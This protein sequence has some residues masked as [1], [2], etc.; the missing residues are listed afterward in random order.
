MYR[1][2]GHARD[3]KYSS[4]EK[5]EAFFVSLFY[6][7]FLSHLIE[8]GM[9]RCYFRLWVQDSFCPSRGSFVRCIHVYNCFFLIDWYFCHKMSSLIKFFFV[10]MSVLS[11]ISIATPASLWFLFVRYFLFFSF[12]FNLS[13]LLSIYI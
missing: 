7:L 10:L 13:L 11:N 12:A 1:L 4:L 6:Y 5:T 3:P 8:V 2:T 9:P